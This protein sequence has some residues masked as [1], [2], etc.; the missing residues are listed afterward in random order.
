MVI[1]ITTKNK[2]SNTTVKSGN[3][4]PP[5]TQTD[6]E[7]EMNINAYGFG[8][9]FSVINYSTRTADIYPFNNSYKT[10]KHILI[11]T[12]ATAYKDGVMGTPYIFDIPWGSV[13]WN[14]TGSLDDK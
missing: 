13:L 5:N 3:K 11:V 7:Y 14:E 6:N 4:L 10:L 8:N 1:Q 2:V 12:G 9:K